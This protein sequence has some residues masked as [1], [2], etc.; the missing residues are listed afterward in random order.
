MQLLLIF[1]TISSN[2]KIVPNRVEFWNIVK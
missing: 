1:G 2:G